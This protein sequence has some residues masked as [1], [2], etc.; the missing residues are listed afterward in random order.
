MGGRGSDP[1]ILSGMRSPSSFIAHIMIH[2]M[3]QHAQ[4]GGQGIRSGDSPRHG[5]QP[6][7]V[8][9][10][11]LQTTAQF[12]VVPVSAR[13]QKK[14]RGQHRSILNQCSVLP[15]LNPPAHAVITAAYA[16]RLPPPFPP[17]LFST[18]GHIFAIC[19][20]R[21]SPTRPVHILMSVALCSQAPGSS[22]AQ[23]PG[24]TS[25]QRILTSLVGRRLAAGN[26]TEL[27]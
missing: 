25:Q 21:R 3:A 14:R 19:S 16:G 7:L 1:G 5:A 23:A 12:G 15:P 26:K 17:E 27:K 6:L 4:H 24:S 20:G 18:R 2:C 8:H 9:R 11:H 13:L 22:R 10:P